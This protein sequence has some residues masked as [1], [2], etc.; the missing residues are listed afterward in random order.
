M[1]SFLTKVFRLL[2]N[3]RI[4]SDKDD[5]PARDYEGDRE[6]TDFENNNVDYENISVSSCGSIHKLHK[7]NR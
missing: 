4:N 7:P 3:K 1:S 6:Q 5:D 2:K